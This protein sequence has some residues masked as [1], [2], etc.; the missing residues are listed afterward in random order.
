MAGSRMNVTMRRDG[1]ARV[2]MRVR[3]DLDLNMLGAVLA[4]ATEEGV[5]L[6]SM[7]QL[8]DWAEMELNAH[9]TDRIAYVGDTVTAEDL[10]V[11]VK[12]VREMFPDAVLWRRPAA[13][14]QG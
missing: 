7:K 8:R 13:A 11:A 12:Q 9:G 14:A 5:E 1:N 10:E 2:T 4:L 6:R 3:F